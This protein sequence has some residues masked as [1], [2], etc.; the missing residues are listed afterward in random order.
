MALGKSES[1][2]RENQSNK[3]ANWHPD[4]HHPA[5]LLPEKQA[6]GERNALKSQ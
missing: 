6:L 3:R 5:A 1:M 4:F 2:S